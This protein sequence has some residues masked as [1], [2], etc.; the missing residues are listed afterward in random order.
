MQEVPTC[1]LVWG[2]CDRPCAGFLEAGEDTVHFSESRFLGYEAHFSCLM[3]LS[4]PWRKYSSL[5]LIKHK[6]S[7]MRWYSSVK[8]QL[9]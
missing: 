4:S 6:V 1:D 9:L 8:G 3:V 7:N 5:R 2:G